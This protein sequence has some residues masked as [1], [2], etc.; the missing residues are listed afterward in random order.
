[1]TG[2]APAPPDRREPQPACR[3]RALSPWLVVPVLVALGVLALLID[4]AAFESLADKKREGLAWVQMLRAA[5]YVPTWLLI[6]A[7]VALAG[8]TRSAMLH[9][10]FIAGSAALSGAIAEVAKVLLRQARPDATGGVH[11]FIAWSEDWTRGF[12]LPSSHAAVAF[13]AAFAVAWLWPRAGAVALVVAAGC[14]LTRVMMGAH[15]VS[16]VAAGALVGYAVAWGL[17]F[18]SSRWSARPPKNDRTQQP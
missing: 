1:M 16:D 4:Q 5:G 12:G 7:G 9:A 15:F 11:R 8:W 6:A 18:A 17:A 13:G 10:A 14:G 2:T 3:P